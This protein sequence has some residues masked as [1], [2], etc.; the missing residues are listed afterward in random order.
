MLQLFAANPGCVISREQLYEK[1]W[2]ESMDGIETRTV[3]MHIVRLRDLL[4]E[5]G[6]EN[7]LIETVRGAGYKYN[8]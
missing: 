3:D 6:A 5:A 1:C 7:E 8:V 2:H 4:K